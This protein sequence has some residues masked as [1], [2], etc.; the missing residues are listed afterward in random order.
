MSPVHR[1]FHCQWQK[2]K[3]IHHCQRSRGLSQVAEAEEDARE[4]RELVQE[5]AA[6]AKEAQR[7][8]EEAKREAGPLLRQAQDSEQQV[9]PFTYPQI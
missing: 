3:G 7:Q 9:K 5:Q 4:A 1:A 2:N 8:A 6:V